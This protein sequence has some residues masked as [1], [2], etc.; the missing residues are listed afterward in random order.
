MCVSEIRIGLRFVYGNLE[1]LTLLLTRR[2]VIYQRVLERENGR[3]AEDVTE[4][5]SNTHRVLSSESGRFCVFRRFKTSVRHVL[6]ARSGDYVSPSS[7]SAEN[8]NLGQF[9]RFNRSR[10][11]S[12][13]R[14]QRDFM[15]AYRVVRGRRPYT[16]LVG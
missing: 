3:T 9:T 7:R 14:N 12:P 2:F 6:V 15:C 13:L 11:T 4:R 8:R 5:L 1:I 10:L 16:F